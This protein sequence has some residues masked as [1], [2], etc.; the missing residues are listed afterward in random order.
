MYVEQLVG[1]D[2]VNTLPP[3]TLEAFRDHG[4]VARTV[5]KD[6][7]AARRAI[8]DLEAAGISLRDVTEKLLRDGIQSFQKSFDG[9]LVRLAKP[10]MS[11]RT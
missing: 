10:A 9:L 11:L 7:D 1:P 5:D 8:A 4:E 6:L 3:A 2:T